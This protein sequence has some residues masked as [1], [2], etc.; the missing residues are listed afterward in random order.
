M[1]W[2]GVPFWFSCQAVCLS[3]MPK[4]ETALCLPVPYGRVAQAT[5]CN[6]SVCTRAFT[7][8]PVRR[9][10]LCCLTTGTANRGLLLLCRQIPNFAVLNLWFNGLSVQ[11]W[12]HTSLS[13]GALFCESAR[14]FPGKF[15][16]FS[17]NK[18]KK[19]LNI[20]I[21]GFQKFFIFFDFYNVDNQ[22]FKNF[23]YV[24]VVTG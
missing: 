6:I 3:G 14:N 1:L 2:L 18:Y 21:K 24:G 9:A 4:P 19:N 13:A 23:C 12:R 7:L 15:R 22:L 20:K 5:L 16:L 11:V 8:T 10:N 17:R